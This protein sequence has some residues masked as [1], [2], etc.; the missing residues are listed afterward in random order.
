MHWA[1]GIVSA[2]PGVETGS[3]SRTHS[4]H[5]ETMRDVL[6][7][8]M[9]ASQPFSLGCPSAARRRTYPDGLRFADSNPRESTLAP[10]IWVPIHRHHCASGTLN[11]E[12]L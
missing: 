1:P 3:R 8:A 6:V 4:P 5:P 2:P 9:K 7:A 12:R 10:F 11:V